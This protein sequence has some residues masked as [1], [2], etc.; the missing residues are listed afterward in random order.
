[1]VKNFLLFPCF[2]FT[3][4]KYQ[5]VFLRNVKFKWLLFMNCNFLKVSS[6]IWF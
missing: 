5:Y 3:D 1:M 2:L 4:F 6:F